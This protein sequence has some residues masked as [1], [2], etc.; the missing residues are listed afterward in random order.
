MGVK[1]EN[2]RFRE[3]EKSGYREWKIHKKARSCNFF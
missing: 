2:W 3:A 1:V